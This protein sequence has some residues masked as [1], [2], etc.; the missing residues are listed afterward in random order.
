MKKRSPLTVTMYTPSISTRV[1]VCSRLRIVV[2]RRER[3]DTRRFEAMPFTCVHVACDRA[4]SNGDDRAGSSAIHST[5]R[6]SSTT[7]GR[8]HANDASSPFSLHTRTCNR[9]LV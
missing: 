9:A 2:V 6:E 7:H 8:T 1:F 4:S 5:V 3:K